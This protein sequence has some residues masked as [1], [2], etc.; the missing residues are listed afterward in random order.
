M[1][2]C[3][4]HHYVDLNYDICV[5]VELCYIILLMIYSGNLILL[6]VLRGGESRGEVLQCDERIGEA[7]FRVVLRCG[8]TR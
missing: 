8:K 7:S 2:I 4:E 5:F 3:V 1:Q 6:V